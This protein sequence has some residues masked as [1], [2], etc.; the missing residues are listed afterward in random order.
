MREFDYTTVPTGL[1]AP[2]VTRFLTD[3]HEHKGAQLLWRT[4]R[5]ETLDALMDVAKVESVGASNRIEGIATTQP[6]LHGIVL[7]RT[8]PHGRA[9]EEI[10]GYRDVLALIHEQHDYIDV[11]PS[12]IL[13]LHRDLLRHTPLSY[14][15]RWKD[16]DNAIVGV[17][18]EGNRVTRF[19][20]TPAIMTPEAMERLCLALRLGLGEGEGDPLLT[21]FRFVFDFICIHPFNDGNGRMSRLLTVLL[22]EKQGYDVV[23]YVSMERLIEDSK[24]AYYTALA[25]G[26]DRWEEGTN[27][28]TPFVCYMLGVL[29][30]AYRDMDDRMRDVTGRIVGKAERVKMVFDRHV[31]K[32][33][34]GTIRRECPDVSDITI[35]RA[36][37]RMMKERRIRRVGSGRN[38]GYVRI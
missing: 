25:A 29:L 19:V 37:R 27:D 30:A 32:V 26:S 18:H 3:I 36:L 6:R 8:E 7:H 35:T 17:D 1:L 10:S 28:E 31:G 2:D 22:L 4:A 33:T 9:E 23:R 12:V 21:I 38:T 13:Q 11:T 5:T 16:V 20:P 15:G 34:R 14:G 24:G